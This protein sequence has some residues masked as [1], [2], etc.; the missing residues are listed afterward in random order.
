[1][2]KQAFTPLYL[3]IMKFSKVLLWLSLIGGAGFLAFRHLK[4]KA[5]G[6][7]KKN[8]NIQVA[9]IKIH[10]ISLNA[11]EFKL[12]LSLINLTDISVNI[13]DL[14]ALVFYVKNG[15][16]IPFAEGL[17]TTPLKIG[18]KKS[19]NFSIRVSMKTADVIRNW[20]NIRTVLSTQHFPGKVVLSANVDGEPFNLM[21]DFNLKF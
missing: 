10:K 14:K 21:Q 20:S 5:P 4:S 1:M 18:A 11:V 12:T 19:S 2:D 9:N 7:L 13:T 17:I 15:S 16:P 6:F 8:V 3:R